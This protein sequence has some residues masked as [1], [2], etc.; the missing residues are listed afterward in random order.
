[1]TKCSL[2]R[3]ITAS[4]DCS[5][6]IWDTNMRKCIKSY[7]KNHKVLENKLLFCDVMNLRELITTKSPNFRTKEIGTH[8]C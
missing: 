4:S 1:M 3:I 7:F 2:I 5:V 6:K 8:C